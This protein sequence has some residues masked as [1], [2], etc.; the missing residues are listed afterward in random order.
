MWVS[1]VQSNA[2]MTD[3][4]RRTAKTAETVSAAIVHDVV[5]RR[6]APGDML[7]SEAAMLSQY[8]VSR[9]S[10]REGL[11]LLEVQGLIRLKPGPAA[12]PSSGPSTRGRW[13]RS[14]RCTSTSAV[15]PTGSCST[16]SCS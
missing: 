2:D 11:R 12:G 5:S 6:L 14:R 15:R 4:P 8:K 10:L 9:A 7:P 16:P 1:L 13:P 3:Q